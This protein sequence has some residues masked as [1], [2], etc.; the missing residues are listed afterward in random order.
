M[1]LKFFRQIL[2]DKNLFKV[3]SVW[4]QHPA[5]VSKPF[6][7]FLNEF[8]VILKS[9]GDSHSLHI[10]RGKGVDKSFLLVDRIAKSACDKVR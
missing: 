7:D 8:S 10:P 9:A 6:A 3:K 1:S 4:N 2:A 5:A